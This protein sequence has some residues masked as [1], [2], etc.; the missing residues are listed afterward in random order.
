MVIII[1]SMGYVY[2]NTFLSLYYIG[3]QNWPV[4]PFTKRK[5]LEKYFRDNDV[6]EKYKRG[7]QHLYCGHQKIT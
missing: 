6:K 2:S 3:W 5:L 7:R 1:K 4:K